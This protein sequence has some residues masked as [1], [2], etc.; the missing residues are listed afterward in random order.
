MQ[1][2]TERKTRFLTALLLTIVFYV[3]VLPLNEHIAFVQ[4]YVSHRAAT[5]AL[6]LKLLGFPVFLSFFYFIVN[7][8]TQLCTGNKFYRSWLKNTAFYAAIMLILLV[9]LY[10]G[11][12]VGD[13]FDILEAVRQYSLYSWQNYLT[14]IFYTFSLYLIP[15]GVGIVIVQL[16]IVSLITG[17]VVTLSK[18]L[19]TKRYTHYF[20]FIP[21]LFFP[22]ILNNFYPLRLTLFSYLLLLLF[23]I[24]FFLNKRLVVS[25]HPRVLFLQIS[26]IL[27]V[28]CFWR[29]EG[30]IYIILL[31]LFAHKLGLLNIKS[32]KRKS[33]YILL[34]LAISFMAAVFVVVAST[35]RADYQI[36]ATLNPLSTMV[37][38]KLHGKNLDKDLG[39]INRV[40]DLSVVKKYPSFAEIPSFWKGAVRDDYT[41]HLKEYNMHIYNLFIEN[42]DLFFANRIQVFLL[43]N[44]FGG[45]PSLGTSQFFNPD[46]SVIQKVQNF[47]TTN[48]LSHPI[49]LKLKLVATKILLVVDGQF[50]P[51]IFTRLIW[52]IIPTSLALIIILVGSLIRRHWLSAF[53]CGLLLLHVILIFLTA[54]ASYFM[55]YF[56]IYLIGNFLIVIFLLKYL[57][58]SGTLLQ[59]KNSAIKILK[60]NRPFVFLL[61]GILNTTLD[62]LFYSLLVHAVFKSPDKIFLVG[63]ISGTFALLCAY[64]THRFITWRD[65]C[66]SSTSIL[67]FFMV[68]GFGLWIIRPLLL[69]WFITFTPIHETVRDLL[70]QSIGLIVDNY[71]VAS[72]SAFLGMVGILMIYNFF[73]YGRFV[74]TKSTTEVTNPL[75][76]SSNR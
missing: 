24:L 3:I 52:S 5:L 1:Y 51:N 54:P 42:S 33:T 71:T 16:G 20:L 38:S 7:F 69:S 45:F 37:Q 46:S 31:P 4:P 34:A 13:E 62:F 48:R 72:T 61:V 56:P 53:L 10:P 66:V 67:K 49:S 18:K 43:A 8:V 14:N 55:Y 74:F 60:S 9:V 27:A 6:G 30:I 17:Y 11:H 40:V 23:A 19:F 57:E 35:T 26:I 29:S 75:R 76:R 25:A 39:A 70:A 2:F 44:S 64:T 21:F 68:T 63:I 15:T 59:V 36:T 22:V 32:V 50:R 41:D 28:V 12:W 58:R 73:M 47:Y 65:R